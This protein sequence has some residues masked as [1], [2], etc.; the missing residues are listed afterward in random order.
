MYLNKAII[1]RNIGEISL[2]EGCFSFDNVAVISIIE[3]LSSSSNL[4]SSYLIG[5]SAVGMGIR[6]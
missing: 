6:I 2:I 3:V 1:H 5:F 4:T